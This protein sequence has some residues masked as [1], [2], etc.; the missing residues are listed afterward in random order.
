MNIT[1]NV[2]IPDDR[3]MQLVTAY[4]NKQFEISTDYYNRIDV[5][6]SGIIIQII[7]HQVSEFI[8]NLDFTG[9]IRAKVEE[10]FPTIMEDVINKS[11]RARVMKRVNELRKAGELEGL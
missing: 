7:E 9:E 5:A 8:R 1:I 10:L 4:V 2:T 11:I 6:K 3:L